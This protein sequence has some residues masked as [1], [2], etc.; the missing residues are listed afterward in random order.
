[1]RGIRLRGSFTSLRSQVINL[2]IHLQLQVLV[3]LQV[4]QSSN[5]CFAID[6]WQLAI[7]SLQV[8]GLEIRAPRPAKI[9]QP[10]ASA[11]FLVEPFFVKNCICYYVVL[12][13]VFLCLGS[14]LGRFLGPNLGPKTFKNGVQEPLL[15]PLKK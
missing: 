10:T 8:L 1:M 7:G 4:K 3:S 2:L 13:M 14:L 6:N 11:G 9:R 15:E 5:C 12:D